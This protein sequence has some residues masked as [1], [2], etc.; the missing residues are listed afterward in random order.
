M[1]EEL[2]SPVIDLSGATTATL[3]FD[4]WFRWRSGEQ[5]EVG[6]LDIRSSLTAGAWVNL[7]SWTG[8]TAN[9]VHEAFDITAL[10]AG[11]ADVEV[12]WHYYQAKF[13]WTWF[14]DNV[15]V[16]YGAPGTC[17][18]NG[19][20]SGPVTPPPPVPD[21]SGGTAGMTVTAGGLPDQ[22]VV[23]WDDQCAASA[24]ILYGP[25][26]QVSTYGLLGSI[27]A[28]ASP[29]AW[30]GVPAGDLWFLLVSDDGLGTESTWGQATGGERNGL[31]ASGECGTSTKDVW[32][33]CP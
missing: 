23:Q 9:P 3:E 1:D 24:N 16:S 28:V 13:E 31:T 11:A 22:L 15:V 5:P 20:G 4:H 29:A 33:T 14:L 6:D 18:M 21:G 12:R 17:L 25:L 8:E 2:I 27:C 32:G 30:D 10:A 7:A 19:C 26:A